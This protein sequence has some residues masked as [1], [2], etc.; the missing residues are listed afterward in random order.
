MKVIVRFVA[1]VAWVGYAPIAPG[2]AASA[3]A[4]VVLWF[5][6][7]VGPVTSIATVLFLVVIGIWA[8]SQAEFIYGHDASKIVIDEF[9]GYFLALLFL[10]K[11]WLLLLL[12]FFLFRFFD[13]FK[14]Y[15]LRRAERLKRGF[16]VMADDLLAGVYTNILLRIGI[17]VTNYV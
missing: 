11:T 4:A 14:P 10:P 16:G 7:A 2:T 17:W 6:P 3:A 5:I 8:S 15:P 12:G 9:A 1:T 13:I